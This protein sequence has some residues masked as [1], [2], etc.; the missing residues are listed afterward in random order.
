MVTSAS[1][2]YLNLDTVTSGGKYFSRLDVPND[3]VALATN[4]KTNTI[5]TCPIINSAPTQ[6]TWRVIHLLREDQ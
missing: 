5:K 4:V 1:F 6:M 3:D 2:A